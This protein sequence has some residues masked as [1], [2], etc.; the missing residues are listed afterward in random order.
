MLKLKR[1]SEIYG[2][3]V[4]TDEGDFFGE[5]E[6]VLLQENR[7]YGW[8]IRIAYPELL[9]EGIKGVIVPHQLVRAIGD[10]MIISKAALAI[11]KEKKEEEEKKE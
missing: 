1:I 8:K 7:I 4:Y 9:Q 2:K 10:I 3:K 11:K 6:D 5:V